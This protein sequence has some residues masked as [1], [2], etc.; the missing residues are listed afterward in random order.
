MLVRN[1]GLT[2]KNTTMLWCKSM[3]IESMVPCWQMDS[4]KTV[5]ARAIPIEP[6]L[7]SNGD[8]ALIRST[9]EVLVQ[10]ILCHHLLH[11]KEYYSDIVV[12]HIPHEYSKESK[13]RTRMVNR[14]K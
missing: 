3:V 11:F 5:P 4:V 14:E 2:G 12:S 10:R 6:I 13:K 1:Q 9:L 8:H 7:P